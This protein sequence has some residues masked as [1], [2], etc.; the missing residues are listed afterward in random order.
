MVLPQA[1][2]AESHTTTVTV[3]VH[4]VT[5]DNARRSSVTVVLFE[6]R[7]IDRERN[8][9]RAGLDKLRRAEKGGRR[10]RV[11]VCVVDWP[12]LKTDHG[13]HGASHLRQ[14][15]PVGLAF[16]SGLISLRVFP[17]FSSRALC[18]TG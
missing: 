18:R 2:L 12:V 10:G 8:E 3:T 11:V 15:W 6:H 4:T 7:R 17:D 14:L 1:L 13:D 16:L 9:G 5:R